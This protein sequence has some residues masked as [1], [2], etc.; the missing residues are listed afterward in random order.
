MGARPAAALAL[1][2]LPHGG[3]ALQEEDLF[4]M[5]AGAAGV[6]AAEGCA[7]GGGHTCEGAELALGARTGP[8]AGR[9]GLTR[10]AGVPRQPQLSLP[11]L[12][13]RCG[14]HTPAP[15]PA[16]P[17]R[18]PAGF[19]VTGHAPEAALLRKGGLRPGDV[20]ILT[21]PLGTGTILAAA[22]RGAARGRWVSDALASM[23]QSSGPAARALAAH[24]CTGCTD[25]TGFGLLGHAAELARA[26]GVE[27]ELN[28]AAVPA[29]P[30][31]LECIAAGH[32]SSLH[33]ANAAALAVT[34]GA[35]RLTGDDSRGVNAW[36]LLADPQTAGGLLAGVPAAAAAAA[37]A[38]VRTAGCEHAAVVGR[39]VARRS[40]SGSGGSGE[41]GEGG[42]PAAP[43]LVICGA[44][45]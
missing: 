13:G 31:A 18:A 24:G 44:D 6:L 25:V 20:L 11:A 14:A 22:M 21:K 30:G 10:V 17:Q 23:Q 32:L 12:R 41:G 42:A 36:A 39:A 29:L 8:Q 35:G 27:V 1:A 38:A 7:L 19:S 40:S 26:S 5:L 45:E 33:P 34:D 2:V 15:A 3:A 4:Q 9:A 37:L 43:L 28:P 16:A